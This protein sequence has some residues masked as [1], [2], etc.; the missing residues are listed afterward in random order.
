MVQ[1]IIIGGIA[2]AISF[3]LGCTLRGQSPEEIHLART[4]EYPVPGQVIIPI[5]YISAND[6]EKIPDSVSSRWKGYQMINLNA[7]NLLPSDPCLTAF[8]K[9]GKN[10]SARPLIFRLLD[11]NKA[12]LVFDAEGDY[13]FDN[14]TRDTIDI[15][16]PAL[17]FKPICLWQ[18]GLACEIILPL[19]INVNAVGGKF[20]SIEIQN[21]LQ[22]RARYL[23]EGDTLVVNI[24]AH[25]YKMWC[26]YKDPGVPS[27]SLLSFQINEPFKFSGKWY[28]LSNIDLCGNKASIEAVRGDRIQGF[29]EGQYVDMAILR[30]LTEKNLMTGSDAISWSNT[31]FFLLHFWGEWCAPCMEELPEVKA[32]DERLSAK[33]KVQMIYYPFIFK[34]TLISRTEACISNNALSR[35]Q[36]YCI[37]KNCQLEAGGAEW[38]NVADLL[39]VHALPQFILVGADGKIWLRTSRDG[40]SQTILKLKAL[41][42]Y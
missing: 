10:L 5:L 33:G 1:K 18:N 14:N 13:Y 7:L 24:Q 8:Y 28:R 16:A 11:K 40:L 30:A 2:T 27:D 29:R 15:N 9:Q 39:N 12:V 37:P 42:L 17:V 35:R 32:L 31:P 41:D 36:S 20:Q 23:V 22:Y 21:Y 4:F 6:T 3:L 26:Y 25:Y 34:D 19:M 38:C